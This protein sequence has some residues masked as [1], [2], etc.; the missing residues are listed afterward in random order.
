MDRSLALRNQNCLISD[1]QESKYN[2][3]SCHHLYTK[4]NQNKLTQRVRELYFDAVHGHE[5]PN[6][7]LIAGWIDEENTIIIEEFYKSFGYPEYEIDCIVAQYN[8]FLSPMIDLWVEETLQILGYPYLN[9]VK[10]FFRPR[11]LYADSAQI[12]LFKEFL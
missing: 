2:Y 3:L 11:N 5:I 6:L 9:P 8:Q 4:D 1:E 12:V 7:S 10:Y